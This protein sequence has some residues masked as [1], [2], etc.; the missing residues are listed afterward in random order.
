MK[1]VPEMLSSAHQDAKMAR[2]TT[3]DKMF[4]D[5]VDQ[6]LD[7][8]YRYLSNLTRDE[9]TARDLCHETFLN[10]RRHVDRGREITEAYVFTSARNTAL[11]RWRRDKREE[12]KREAWG[13]EF[14][15]QAM[16]ANSAEIKDLRQALQTALELL[17]EEHRSVFLLSEVEGL[18]YEKIAEVLEISAGTVA[19]RKFNAN[20]ILRHELKRMGHELP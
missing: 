20:R 8:V 7:R 15:D 16:S 18:K 3:P 12:S 5:L 11:S 6:Y 19:S 13:R 9:D 14:E 2:R 17:S 4:L 10:L 1:P